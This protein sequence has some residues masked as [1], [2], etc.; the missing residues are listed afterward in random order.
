MLSHTL[1]IVASM[2]IEIVSA[3]VGI[4]IDGRP[5]ADYRNNS[6]EFLRQ[7]PI[8]GYKPITGMNAEQLAWRRI[9]DTT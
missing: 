3:P 5:D 6:V 7:G 1:H 4:R 2:L 9:T 8:F